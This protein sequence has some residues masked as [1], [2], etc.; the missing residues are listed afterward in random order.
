MSPEDLNTFNRQIKM[1]QTD[2]ARRSI[3]SSWMPHFLECLSHQGARSKEI[4][5]TLMEVRDSLVKMVEDIQ[6]DHQSD[7]EEIV[8]MITEL[9]QGLALV[10][11]R[12]KQIPQRTK[13]KDDKIGWMMENWMQLVIIFYIFKS[14]FGVGI[15]GIIGIVT[16]IS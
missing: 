13:F 1:A 12:M 11:E 2:D 8:K 16:K 10:A 14:L 3:V 9:S 6:K 4:Y 5:S 7:K 15:D